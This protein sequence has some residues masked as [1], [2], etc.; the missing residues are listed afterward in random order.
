MAIITLP[1]EVVAKISAGEVIERPASCVKELIEN[2]IDAEATHIICE[3]KGN[4]VEE[5]KIT[6]NGIGMTMSEMELAIQPH[7]TSKIKNENDLY[8]IRT[9]GFRGEAL[10]SICN[11][12]EV[13]IISKTK[14]DELASYIKVINSQV[15]EKKEINRNY[16]TSVRVRNLFYN[17]PVRRKFL[18]QE[19]I[20]VQ[21]IIEIIKKLSLANPNIYFIFI[22]NGKEILNLQK[23]KLND[24]VEQI[25]G[26]SVFSTMDYLDYKVDNIHIYG[27]LSKPYELTERPTQIT[28]INK[29]PTKGKIIKEAIEGAYGITLKDKLPSFVLFVDTPTDFVDVNIHPRKEEIRFKDERIIHNIIFKGL[30]EKLGIKPYWRPKR[31]EEEFRI[32]GANFFQLYKSYILVE[33]EDGILIIDQHAAHERIMY[34]KLL[35]E[36]IT[37]QE[38]L[39][40][41]LV[42]LTPIEEKILNEVQDKLQELGFC[43][44]RFGKNTIR[45]TTIPSTLKE[46]TEE[47]FKSMIQELA[48]NIKNAKTTEDKINEAIKTIACRAAIK[49]NTVLKKE[50]MKTLVE[51]LFLT[52]NRFFCPHG[53]PTMLKFTKQ[54]LAQKFN[55]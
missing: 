2:S 37:P 52:N 36:K 32:E 48:E 11:V 10:P 42:E 1:N 5:I 28:L 34:E 33:A 16:G 17:M 43:I 12:A 50:E 22:H 51:T 7:T 35:N 55:R 19:T 39:F 4:G 9:M 54:E 49:S 40:P 26:K 41:V 14:N 21:Q 3:I 6:D 20:E 18:P 45:I 27:Y 8:N 15:V 30:S 13:E 44:E 46:I 29:R 47:E 25:L 31:K 23:Q 24:R 53:R 38:L